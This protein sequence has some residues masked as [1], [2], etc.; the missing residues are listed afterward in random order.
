[1]IRFVAVVVAAM[2]LAAGCG[3]GSG[4]SPGAGGQPR[5][6]RAAPP[7]RPADITGPVATV[8]DAGDG[9]GTVLIEEG[10]GSV[11][12]ASI[13]VSAGTVVLEADG[14]GWRRATLGAITEGARVRA[15]FI[16]PVAESYPVQ[17]TA[18]VIAIEGG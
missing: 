11:D 4:A 12:A 2:T 10:R 3:E 1:M 17:A 15:W 7:R 13:R 18:A 9:V 14:G 5:P 6:G 8:I 16:G